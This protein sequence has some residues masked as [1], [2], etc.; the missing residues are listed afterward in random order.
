MAEPGEPMAADV[1]VADFEP[2][3][4]GPLLHRVRIAAAFVASLFQGLVPPPG[5]HDVVVRRQDDGSEVARILVEDP[6]LPGNTLRFVQADLDA[7]SPEEFVA[8]WNPRP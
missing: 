8:E 3:R 1:F 2:R 4:G 5:V 6:D 7:R